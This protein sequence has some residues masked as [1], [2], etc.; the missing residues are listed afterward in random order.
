MGLIRKRMVFL[1]KHSNPLFFYLFIFFY[2][3]ASYLFIL[4]FYLSTFSQQAFVKYLVFVVERV[5]EVGDIFQALVNEVG[6][7]TKIFLHLEIIIVM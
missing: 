1:K 4:C 7:I 5:I 2:F 3:L 6:N